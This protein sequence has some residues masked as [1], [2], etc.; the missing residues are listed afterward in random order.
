MDTRP[1]VNPTDRVQ[2]FEIEGVRYE[3]PA[4]GLVDIPA[5]HEHVVGARRMVIRPAEAVDAAS[6][7]D[8]PRAKVSVDLPPEVDAALT[9]SGA[10]EAQRASFAEEWLVA[11]VDRRT[12]LRAEL[13][14]HAARAA[15]RARRD[16]DRDTEKADDVESVAE[17]AGEPPDDDKDDADD[18]GDEEVA[19][20]TAQ[21]EAAAKTLRRQR[22]P[23]VS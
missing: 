10:T 4:G 21:I 19:G 12:R 11:S 13:L 6:A 14:S 9:A 18:A 20:A 23:K 7:P 15:A 5:E 16:A 22:A 8:A 1:Y 2:R 3:V 17:V